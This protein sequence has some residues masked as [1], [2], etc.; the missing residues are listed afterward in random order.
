MLVPSGHCK[1]SGVGA[2]HSELLEGPEAHDPMYGKEQGYS[3]LSPI[4]AEL[5]FEGESYEACALPFPRFASDDGVADSKRMI[6]LAQFRG[7]KHLC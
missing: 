6:V 2:N 7:C 4:L 1:A 3:F 5:S